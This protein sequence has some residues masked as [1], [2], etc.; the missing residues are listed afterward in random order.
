MI[1]KT[2]LL[3]RKYIQQVLIAILFVPL[4]VQTSA[5]LAALG[6]TG[7]LLSEPNGAWKL[8]GWFGA[9]WIHAMSG[10]SWVTLFVGIS[11]RNVPRELEEEAIQSTSEWHVLRQISLRHSLPGIYAAALWITVIC[12]GEIT[13]T[14]MFQVRTFAEEVYTAASLGTLN[15]LQPSENTNSVVVDVPELVNYDLWLGTLIFALL[16]GSALLVLWRWLNI[17]TFA[18]MEDRWRIVLQKHHWPATLATWMLTLV[19]IGVPLVSLVIKSGEQLERIDNKT[20]STW[21]LGQS[22]KLITSSPWEHRRELGWTMAIGIVA[23]VSAV[24]AGILLAW[25]FQNRWLP[26]IPLAFLLA[27]FFALPGPILAVWL[28]KLMNHPSQ[29][30]LNFLTWLYDYT[31]MAPAVVQFLRSVPIA[32]LVLTM[33]FASVPKEIL[34]N[35]Q[36]EG[37][38]GWQQLFGIVLPMR[39]PGIAAAFCLSLV[40][41]ISD[42]AATLLVLPPG[43]T[44]IS[45]RVFGLIHYGAEDRVAALSFALAA[46]TA[47]LTLLAWQLLKRSSRQR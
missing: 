35:A 47:L 31:I 16:V 42:L 30:S 12:F 45:T 17:S 6:Q 28:I 18:S 36:S 33:Q 38:S 3:G 21:S 7:W 46:G 9:I 4:Y 32:T 20:V 5:W 19:I 37:A 13:V 25:T 39:F 34:E 1:T 27:F 44:T 2:S 40:V 8:S 15:G 43:V 41:A 11:L 22:T 10:I 24:A 23:S 29:S 14:D 26:K